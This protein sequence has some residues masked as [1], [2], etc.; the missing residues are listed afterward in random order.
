MARGSP[1]PHGTRRRVTR[2]LTSCAL[3][4]VFAACADRPLAPEGEITLRTDARAYIAVQDAAPGVPTRYTLEMVVAVTN[5]TGREIALQACAD[6]SD[7]P[8]F[9]VSMA[10]IRSDWSAAYENA[11][12]CADPSYRI[13]AVGESRVDRIELVAP[14]TFDALTGRALGDLE[15]EM[16]LAYYVDDRTLWS[17][18]FDVRTDTPQRLP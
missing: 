6:N 8:R 5:N 12:S 14:R 11:W 13:L 15:G 2:R 7:A 9:A 1:S 4:L 10:R 17:N 18:A 3:A 16:R